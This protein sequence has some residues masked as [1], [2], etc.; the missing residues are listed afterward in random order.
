[1]FYRYDYEAEFYPSLNRLPL[2]VRRKLDIAGI[3][4]SLKDWLVFGIEE[5]MVLCHMPCDNDEERLVFA[6]FMDFLARKYFGKPTQK[7]EP[8]DPAFW[9]DLTVP[10]AV[11]QRSTAL[12]QVVT[13]SEWRHWPAHHRY[14]LY[15]SAL[16]DKQ[17]EAF[18]HVL[19]QLRKQT[20]SN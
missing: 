1:M 9:T 16:S 20:P 2:D 19:I 10:D 3:K 15:K 7:I 6:S 12:R 14:A 11:A 17:P 4:I 13:A 8:L 18:E 5:R